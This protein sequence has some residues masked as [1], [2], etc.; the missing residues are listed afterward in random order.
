MSVK[1]EKLKIERYSH[2]LR[3]V[4][5]VFYWSAIIAAIGSLIAAA[6]IGLMSDSKFL[7]GDGTKAHLGFSLDGVIRYNLKDAAVQRISTRN[8]YITIM[9]MS[10]A[11]FTLAVPVLRQ[12]VLILKSVEECRPFTRENPGRLSII[13]AIILVGSFL[14]PACETAVAKVIIDTLKIQNIGTN[15]SANFILILTGFMM[16]ILGGIFKYGS[17]L[18]HEYDETV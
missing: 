9:L 2:N 1:S 15:Y 16:F 11:M 4:L 3:I 13:G 10:A 17:Y 7:I 8:I 12:L 6:V 18:Q 14:I 5:N